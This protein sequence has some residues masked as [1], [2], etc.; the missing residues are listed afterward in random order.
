MFRC[1]INYEMIYIV[2]YVIEKIKVNEK[3]GVYCNK[4]DDLFCGMILRNLY[5]INEE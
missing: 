5:T 4:I 3:K 1:G 2:K